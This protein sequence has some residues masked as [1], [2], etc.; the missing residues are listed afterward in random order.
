MTDTQTPQAGWY[1]DPAGTSGARWWTGSGWTEHTQ[2]Y[3]DPDPEGYSLEYARPFADHYAD[4]HA[5]VYSD[6][7]AVAHAG[8]HAEPGAAQNVRPQ[9]SPTADLHADAAHDLRT[10]HDFRTAPEI[11]HRAARGT[12]SDEPAYVPFATTEVRYTAASRR[13]QNVPSA[14]RMARWGQGF[15][16]VGAILFVFSVISAD[17]GLHTAGV[18]FLVDG[19]LFAMLFASGVGIVAIVLSAIG[20]ARARRFGGF[21]QAVAGLALGIVFAFSPVIASI[22]I[23]ILAL[24]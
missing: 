18:P 5:D 11:L 2:S 16:L 1:T 9:P 23:A 4:R 22:L 14:N 17:V 21:G 6:P 3:A 12:D 13:Y 24:L 20:L 7:Y 10:A 15:G 8:T 19:A